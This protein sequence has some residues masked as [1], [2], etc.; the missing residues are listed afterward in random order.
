M[1]KK[2]KK[3]ELSSTQTSPTLS[4]NYIRCSDSRLNCHVCMVFLRLHKKSK[5]K[6]NIACV[7]GYTPKLNLFVYDK[8]VTEI[9]FLPTT[10]TN[11]IYIFLFDWG[12]DE[13]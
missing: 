13:F 3:I 12:G 8:L 1:K 10:R 7:N 2:E 9:H 6:R 5:E 4:T 11:D